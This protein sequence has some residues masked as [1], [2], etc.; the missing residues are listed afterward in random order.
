MSPSIAQSQQQWQFALRDR[1]LTP[2]EATAVS[3]QLQT[4][5]PGLSPAE[6]DQQVKAMLAQ[7]TGSTPEQASVDLARLRQGESLNLSKAPLGSASLEVSFDFSD[8]ELSDLNGVEA[9]ANDDLSGNLKQ[10]KLNVPLDQAQIRKMIQPIEPQI[11]AGLVANGFS[12]ETAQQLIQH[13]KIEPITQGEQTVWEVSIDQ[14]AAENL[15]FGEGWKVWFANS[16]SGGLTATPLLQ[17]SSN[18]EGQLNFKTGQILADLQADETRTVPGTLWGNREQATGRTHLEALIEDQAKALGLE[19]DIIHADGNYRVE[20][21]SLTLS[22]DQ[23][24][25]FPQLAHLQAGQI[26]L[27]PEQFQVSLGPQGLEIVVNELKLAGGSDR[28]AAAAAAQEPALATDA[29]RLQIRDSKGALQLDDAGQIQGLSLAELNGRLEGQLTLSHEV[30]AVIQAKVQLALQE[31]DQKLAAYGL[32]REQ[33]SQLLSQIPSHALSEVMQSATSGEVA[34]MAQRL[35]I[36]GQNLTAAAR[37]LREEPVQQVLQDLGQLTE[38]LAIDTQVSGGVDF[39]LSDLNLQA[40]EQGFLSQLSALK[41]DFTGQATAPGG[42]QTALKAELASENLSLNTQQDDPQVSSGIGKTSLQLSAESISQAAPV[43]AQ[44]A[45]FQESLAAGGEAYRARTDTQGRAD[46]LEDGASP[47]EGIRSRKGLPVATA[48]REISK[49]TAQQWAEIRGQSKAEQQAFFDAQGIT[50]SAAEPFGAYL[51]AYL[52]RYVIQAAPKTESLEANL[53]LAS[54]A[55]DSHGLQIDKIQADS[56]AVIDSGQ[57]QSQ[58][59]LS[60]QLQVDKLQA[61]AERLGLSQTQASAQTQVDEASGKQTIATANVGIDTLTASAPNPNRQLDQARQVAQFQLALGL[62]GGVYK[63][64]TDTQ[65]REHYLEDG[66]SPAEG[67]R[68]RKGLLLTTAQQEL[69]KA[70]ASE[71]VAILDQ[72]AAE[73]K[74]F[75]AEHGITNSAQAP[76]GDYLVAYLNRYIVSP[77]DAG[78]LNASQVSADADIQSTGAN[79]AAVDANAKLDF[80]RIHADE[81]ALVAEQGHLSVQANSAGSH[82][83]L[84]TGPGIRIDADQNGISSDSL[85]KW[86]VKAQGQDATTQLAGQTQVTIENG[87]LTGTQTAAGAISGQIQ[88]QTATLL[89]MIQDTSP[90]LAGYFRSNGLLGNGSVTFDVQNTGAIKSGKDGA[91][92]DYQVRASAAAIPTHLGKA[93][94]SLNLNQSGRISGELVINQPNQN[95]P[96][97]I[98][99][100]LQQALI[101]AGVKPEQAKILKVEMQGDKLKIQLNADQSATLD[102]SVQLKGNRIEINLDQA[103]LDNRFTNTLSEIFG[104]DKR[105]ISNEKLAESLQAAGFSPRPN[106]S[107]GLSLD[108][109]VL[110]TRLFGPA[111]QQ[112]HLQPT[113]DAQGRLKISYQLD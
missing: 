43:S 90:E 65:G 60:V 14:A 16:F 82:L 76:T 95:L 61:D 48:Q 42:Q 99:S 33:L 23:L 9:A 106:G 41:L 77:I 94:V 64:H 113:L 31:L 5:Q 74:R 30:V 86:D 49:A 29:T 44:I 98:Q 56:T 38:R 1:Q 84:E 34:T 36:D 28:T 75:F 27:T 92:T 105:K 81:Q 79:Q 108:T 7:A 70:G 25:Q 83:A 97:L 47:A 72:P 110:K 59:Q 15:S 96:R 8:L 112:V 71:W 78:G 68:Q 21:K 88:T 66:V 101:D 109:E 91:L 6:I 51:L 3:A 18:P 17:I 12:A 22:G 40:S 93:A 102:V 37:V 10:L 2:A 39:Q 54:A 4:E 100:S 58:S 55:L 73:Q 69:S 53:G 19:A 107:Y 103:V 35:G 62:G 89:D 67:I 20:P 13:L 26:T 45:A 63:A 50:N 80:G 11:A 111:A 52:D 85:V 24:K 46:Y 87:R 104:V 57:S 32:S